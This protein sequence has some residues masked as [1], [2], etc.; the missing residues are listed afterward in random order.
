MG[1]DDNGLSVG[2]TKSMGVLSTEKLRLSVT[3]LVVTLL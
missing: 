3:R 1:G 2:I